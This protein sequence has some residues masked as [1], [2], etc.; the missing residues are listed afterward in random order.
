M[1]RT[2]KQTLI[3]SLQRVLPYIIKPRSYKALKHN[4]ILPY[5]RCLAKKADGTPSSR[6]PCTSVY[7]TLDQIRN[8][9]PHIPLAAP[10]HMIEGA[11][12]VWRKTYWKKNYIVSVITENH[13]GL[14]GIEYTS[15]TS[16]T[17]SQFQIQI[18]EKE[19]QSIIYQYL[20]W[21]RSFTLQNTIMLQYSS[22]V[23]LHEMC[24]AIAASAIVILDYTQP[25]YTQFMNIF[26]ARHSTSEKN[27]YDMMNDVWHE[28]IC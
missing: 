16:I 26:L 12:A 2:R 24:V 7:A 10:I 28:I 22:S 27:M 17:V 6:H 5:R 3:S 18:T 19:I 8:K 9:Y 20:P 13:I 15:P 4:Y 11:P 25:F 21:V 23:Y 1:V 14:I